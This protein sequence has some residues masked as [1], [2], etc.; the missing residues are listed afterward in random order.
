MLLCDVADEFLDHHGLPHARASE[1][2][3]LPSLEDGADEVDDLDARLQYLRF[4]GLLREGRRGAVDGVVRLCLHLREAVDG[5]AEDVE[6]AAQRLLPDG[7]GDGR[8]GVLHE[9]AA[10]QAVCG[11]H[12]DGADHAPP[13][14]VLDLEDQR[15]LA[16]GCLERREEGREGFSLRERAVDDRTNDLRNVTWHTSMGMQNAK[17]PVVS[18]AEPW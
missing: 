10:L 1:Q 18:G 14:V 16:H 4:R 3:D 15:L 12:G 8:P 11:A 9:R 13:K 6:H 17:A 7:N 2:A 5:L